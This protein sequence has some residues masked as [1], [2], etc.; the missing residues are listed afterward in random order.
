MNEDLKL[1]LS[2]RTLVWLESEIK[3][4]Q[5]TRFEIMRAEIERLRAEVQE[6]HKKA[7]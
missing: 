5:E 3:R 1:E 6:L 4:L 2:M 7:N